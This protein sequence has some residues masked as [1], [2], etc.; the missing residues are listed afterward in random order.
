MRR[1]LFPTVFLLGFSATGLLAACDQ[2]GGQ[3][4]GVTASCTTTERARQAIGGSPYVVAKIG[5]V[6]DERPAPGC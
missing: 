1:F 4:G 3:A 5:R 6:P 2:A